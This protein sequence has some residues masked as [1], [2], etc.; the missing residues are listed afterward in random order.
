MRYT[1]VIVIVPIIITVIVNIKKRCRV[2]T[3]NK[4]ENGGV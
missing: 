4:G 2:V 1:A 3:E